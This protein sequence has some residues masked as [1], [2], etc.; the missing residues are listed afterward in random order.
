MWMYNTNQV[1]DQFET[2]RNKVK[3]V[4]EQDNRTKKI[5]N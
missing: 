4:L 2:K 1:F 3:F 5:R